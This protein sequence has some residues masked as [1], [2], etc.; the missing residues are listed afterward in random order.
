MAKTALQT[1]LPPGTRVR[2]TREGAFHGSVGTVIER[3]PHQASGTRVRWDRY[4]DQPTTYASDV[5][6]QCIE[7]VR[8]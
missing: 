1:Q 3:S 5:S 2:W 4:P 7:E 6:L 8:S